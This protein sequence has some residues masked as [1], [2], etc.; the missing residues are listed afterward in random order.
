MT[1]RLH[2]LVARRGA[3]RV[4]GDR[5]QLPGPG[6]S[7]R[8][9]SLSLRDTGETLLWHSFAGDA[10]TDV[11]AYL[12]G[13][14][15]EIRWMPEREFTP[16]RRP[17]PGGARRGRAQRSVSAETARKSERARTIWSQAHAVSLG[18]PVW[19]YLTVARRLPADIVDDAARA[20][21]LRL[22]AGAP[23]RPMMVALV[24]DR[25]GRAQAIH[26]TYLRPDGRG[27]A[28]MRSPRLMLGRVGGGAV[29]LG[30]PHNGVVALAEG[31][32]TALAFRALHG[33]TCWAA[34]SAAGVQSFQPPASIDALILAIDSDDNGASAAAAERLAARLHGRM[35][36]IVAPPSV[37]R[38]WADEW[39]ARHAR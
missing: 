13:L 19:T 36:C 6:H 3:G 26:R 12:D 21:A 35:R 25:D 28:D 27:K 8:D 20:G 34:L 32:E 24:Q 37:G 33:L 18:D 9:R 22:H 7:N 38:D 11:V 1:A 15:A 31:I 23:R 5:A 4:T 29:R 30:P 16:R 17:R 14:G 10:Q 2:E 39:E